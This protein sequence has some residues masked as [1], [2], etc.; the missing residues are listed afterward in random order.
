MQIDCANSAMEDLLRKYYAKFMAFRNRNVWMDK[1][2]T[3]SH[4]LGR[5]KPFESDFSV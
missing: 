1:I 2:K 4:V 5:T 3:C